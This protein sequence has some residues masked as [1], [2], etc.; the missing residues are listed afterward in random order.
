MFFSILN[1][2][3]ENRARQASGTFQRRSGMFGRVR[4]RSGGSGGSGAFGRRSGAFGRCSGAFGRCS[5][6][7]RACSG[8]VFWHVRMFG[9]GLGA[10][11][12][13]FSHFCRLPRIC[14]EKLLFSRI[15]HEK[16]CFDKKANMR[17]VHWTFFTFL[18]LCKLQGGILTISLVEKVAE[19]V[20]DEHGQ[21]F[22]KDSKDMGL[23]A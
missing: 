2:F 15:F 16:R 4:A 11:T 1:M 12:F 23:R 3:C 17:F 9:L 18:R 10:E 19:L 13:Q 8:A 6:T 5:G 7:V 22:R 14:C 21:I 20:S